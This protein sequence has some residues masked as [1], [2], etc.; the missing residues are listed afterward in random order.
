M[1]KQSYESREIY[2]YDWKTWNVSFIT[3]QYGGV[4]LEPK[5]IV[6]GYFP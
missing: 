2:R 1:Y 6:K 4:G 5:I 3:Y